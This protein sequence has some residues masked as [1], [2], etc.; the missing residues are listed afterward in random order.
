MGGLWAMR[1][2]KLNKQCYPNCL[3]GRSGDRLGIYYQS[4]R[5]LKG[6]KGTNLR[7]VRFTQGAIVAVVIGFVVLVAAVRETLMAVA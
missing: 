4:W 5:D 6:T 3:R 1:R 7:E 2:S